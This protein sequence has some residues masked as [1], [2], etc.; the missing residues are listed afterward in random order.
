M[1]DDRLCIASMDKKINCWD[2]INNKMSLL[3][4]HTE[5]VSA[6]SMDSQN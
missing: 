4:T 3:T 2:N 1:K 6:I 5:E